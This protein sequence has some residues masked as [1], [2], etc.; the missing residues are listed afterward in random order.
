MNYVAGVFKG[1]DFESVLTKYQPNAKFMHEGMHSSINLDDPD[2]R[3][4]M[5]LY[6]RHGLNPTLPLGKRHKF[7]HNDDYYPELDSVI[8]TVGLAE[9]QCVIMSQEPG[10]FNMWHTDEYGSYGGR[11][12]SQI[13]RLLVFLTDYE[14][15]Q[16][17]QWGDNVLQNWSAGDIICEWDRLP[18][19][20]ANASE[21]TRVMLRLTGVVTEKYNSFIKTVTTDFL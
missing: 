9:C 15:C 13:R 1:V 16:F 2:V 20:T 18:H 12:K 5:S 6:I 8:E 7:K 10:M 4:A 21:H 17:L 3:E 14:P 19:G 11:G